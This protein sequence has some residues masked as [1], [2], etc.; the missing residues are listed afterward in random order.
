MRTSTL[1]RSPVVL[2]TVIDDHG[3]NGDDKN[4]APSPLKRSNELRCAAAPSP[5]RELV[6]LGL[7]G[8]RLAA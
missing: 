1:G 4:C 7:S 8:R 2:L 5:Q 6:T 3:G